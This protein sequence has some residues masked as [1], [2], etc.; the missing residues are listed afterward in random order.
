[1]KCCV[2]CEKKKFLRFSISPHVDLLNPL[3]P[4]VFYFFFIRHTN[5]VLFSFVSLQIQTFFFL[6]LLIQ[7]SIS[8]PTFFISTSIRSMS[9]ASPSSHHSKNATNKIYSHIFLLVSHSLTH[10][11]CLSTSFFPK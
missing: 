4:S 2:N 6:L 5:H 1:M 10:S 11:L 8:F 3:S 9:I 7:L